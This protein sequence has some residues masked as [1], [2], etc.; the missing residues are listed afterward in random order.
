L[1]FSLPSL[2]HPIEKQISISQVHSHVI[3]LENISK[4]YYIKRFLFIA[5]KSF[6]LFFDTGEKIE[7]NISFG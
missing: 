3:G 2:Q 1:Y 5:E 6:M 7:K 4:K